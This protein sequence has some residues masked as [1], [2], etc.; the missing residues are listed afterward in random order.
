MKFWSHAT[1][2][3]WVSDEIMELKQSLNDLISQAVVQVDERTKVLT[4]EY[5][6]KLQGLM[7]DIQNLEKYHVDKCQEAEKLKQANKKLEAELEGYTKPDEFEPM[8]ENI[9]HLKAKL[10]STL[11]RLVRNLGINFLEN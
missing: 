4:L 8:E 10:K 9:K 1:R 6:L 11:E 5:E 7:S 3:L 2:L